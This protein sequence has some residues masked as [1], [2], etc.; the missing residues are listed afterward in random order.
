MTTPKRGNYSDEIKWREF[1]F[2]DALAVV[3]VAW[4]PHSYCKT[5]AVVYEGFI[6]I[7]NIKN[8]AQ[9]NGNKQ[10]GEKSN[11]IREMCGTGNNRAQSLS[12]N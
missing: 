5:S 8:I 4:M 11:K 6:S 12:D 9:K 7:F 2:K 10:T 1:I 3:A